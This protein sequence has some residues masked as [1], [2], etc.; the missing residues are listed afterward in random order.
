[1]ERSN[2]QLMTACTIAILAL[3]KISRQF[4]YLL[5]KLDKYFL[6][7]TL[8]RPGEHMNCLTLEMC[9]TG[10]H[11]PPLTTLTF[12]IKGTFLQLRC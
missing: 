12:S 9:H 10:V 11:L 4:N 3:S 7:I 5:L 8:Q 6:A 1:M 2:V